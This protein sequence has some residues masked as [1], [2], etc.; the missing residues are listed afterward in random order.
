MKFSHKVFFSTLLIIALVFSLGTAVLMGSIFQTSIERAG[1][2]TL[3]ENQMLRFSFATAA[4]SAVTTAG[5]YGYGLIDPL[6][7]STI[8][9]IG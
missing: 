9:R 1:Q 2:V 4:S 8:R 5:N 7:D 6:A 3:D